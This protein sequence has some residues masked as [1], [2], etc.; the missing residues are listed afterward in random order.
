M[1][2]TFRELRSPGKGD[3]EAAN[4]D[5]KA[6]RKQEGGFQVIRLE[7]LVHAR[8]PAQFQEVGVA[9]GHLGVHLAKEEPAKEGATEGE[10]GGGESRP[11]LGVDGARAGASEG[12]PH[13]ENQAAQD[14]P[15][16]VIGAAGE[17]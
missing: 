15:A 9:L 12:D 6:S 8:G 16:I 5:G 11:H 14:V 7:E 13:P 4:H 17:G 3:L 10:E 1:G 2:S